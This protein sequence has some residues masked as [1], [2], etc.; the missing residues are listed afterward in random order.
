VVQATLLVGE[1]QSNQNL[2]YKTHFLAGDPFVFLET[3]ERAVLVVSAMEAGR[4]RK[5]S[6][7]SDVRT[8][9]DFGYVD[10]VRETRDR[11]K[12][13]TIMLSRA[14]EAVGADG[15]RV[16]AMFPV[17]YADALRANGWELD[18]DAELYTLQRRRKNAREI[19]AIEEAQRAT[20]RAMARAEAM[21]AGSIV[22]DDTLELEGI[23]LT[24][25][26][27]RAEIELSLMRDGMDVP[28][29]PIV[30]GGAGSADPHWEGVGPIKPGEP[31]VI[32]VFPRGKSARYFADMTR[33]CVKGPPND[34][35]RAMY[36]ATSLALDAALSR[37][38]PG[39][40]AREAHEAAVEVFKEAGF[41]QPD[42]GPR[43]IHPTGHGV[44][45][46]IHE[47]PRLGSLD[48]ELL[49]GDVITVE[50]G[51]YDRVL[52]GIRIED[53]VVVTA[54]GCRNLTAFPRQFE[55]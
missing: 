42:S 23:S 28:L 4:A 55:V 31:V 35:L 27:L 51:L 2:F 14:V 18:V 6:L 15:V 16:E 25:E 47:A 26:R 49:E 38:G 50:P 40:N 22:K 24:S 39:A 37:I 13:F 20:E 36:E 48:V 19:R 33:T 34:T 8:F 10:L 5:E 29:A 1:S 11:T 52:G 12:A 43:Y 9:D 44:G 54:D 32:D 21:L 46:D 3:H 45:L 7:V 17:L 41:D 53:L 30:A